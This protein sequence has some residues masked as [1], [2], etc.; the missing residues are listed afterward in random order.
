MSYRR[1]ILLILVFSL[2]LFVITRISI[3]AIQ[4]N[5]ESPVEVQPNMVLCKD[6]QSDKR[7]RYINP[8]VMENAGRLADPLPAYSSFMVESG[9]R[10]RAGA[11]AWPGTR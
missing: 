1:I 4:D 9:D 11:G 5:P 6:Y 2:A 8:L 3:I 10:W 7:L